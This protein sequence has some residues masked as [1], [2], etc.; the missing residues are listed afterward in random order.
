MR[1]LAQIKDD[2]RSVAAN[3]FESHHLNDFIL[4]AESLVGNQCVIDCIIQ[5][6]T[7]EGLELEIGFFTN[8]QIADVTLSKGKIFFYSYSV[9]KIEAVEIKD[10]EAKWTLTISGEKKFDYNVVKPNLPNALVNY[11]KSLK[12]LINLNK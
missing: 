4:Q 7:D 5:V 12:E 11:E 8:K 6:S 2:I 3:I 1:N 9:E 10:A